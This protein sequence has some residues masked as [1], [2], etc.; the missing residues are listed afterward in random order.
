[1]L[2]DTQTKMDTEISNL[3]KTIDEQNKTIVTLNTQN[4]NA[5]AQADEVKTK[6]QE[7]NRLGS[8]LINNFNM[9]A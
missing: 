4:E 5:K 2:A 7:I 6:I 9:F 8:D 1:M 3:M